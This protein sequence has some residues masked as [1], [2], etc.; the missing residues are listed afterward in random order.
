MKCLSIG[1]FV[2]QQKLVKLCTCIQTFGYINKNKTLFRHCT[3]L[4]SYTWIHWLF[5][6]HTN[7]QPLD[8]V[9]QVHL[10]WGSHNLPATRDLKGH[11]FIH[12]V[13]KIVK[14]SENTRI[15]LTTFN[16]TNSL[17]VS[18]KLRK[19]SEIILCLPSEEGIILCTVYNV[20]HMLVVQKKITQW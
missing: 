8:Q 3:S 10:S 4:A 16:T 5:T 2:T 13:W 12:I 11:N 19:S 18:Q 17:I 15:K 20:F 14:H 9:I 6:R 1:K 7:T